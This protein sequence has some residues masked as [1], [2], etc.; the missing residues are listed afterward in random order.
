MQSDMVVVIIG[1]ATLVLVEVCGVKSALAWW[2]YAGKCWPL[3]GCKMYSEMK[4]RRGCGLC[5]ER[6][7]DRRLVFVDAL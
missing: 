3:S 1:F 2:V 5:S 4:D 6:K 7:Y